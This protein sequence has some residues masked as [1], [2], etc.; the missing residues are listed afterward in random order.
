MHH[1]CANNFSFPRYALVHAQKHIILISYE[2]AIYEL[3]LKLKQS[4]RMRAWF[5]QTFFVRI[6]LGNCH[7][8]R[9]VVSKFL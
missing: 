6:K 4:A 9:A 7:S 8:H 3:A 2:I 1:V 5:L